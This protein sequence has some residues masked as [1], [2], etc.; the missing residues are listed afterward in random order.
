[1]G[2]FSMISRGKFGAWGIAFWGVM[3]TVV[4]GI[5][6]TAS[7]Q[8]E[9]GL[10]RSIDGLAQDGSLPGDAT[11]LDI[12]LTVSAIAGDPATEQLSAL[13]MDETLPPG[14]SFN[15]LVGGQQPVFG[16]APGAQGELPFGYIVVPALPFSFTYRVNVPAEPVL[17]ATFNGIIK[18]RTTGPEL[19]S[20]ES[21]TE[22]VGEINAVTSSRSLSGPG[23]IGEDFYIAGSEFTVTVT[24]EKTGSEAVQA[25][26]YRVTLSPGLSLVSVGGPDTPPIASSIGATGELEFGYIVVPAFPIQF[27]YTLAIAPSVSGP[28][29]LVGE[30]EYRFTEGSAVVSP[31]PIIELEA[32]PCVSFTRTGAVSYRAGD[33]VNFT[34]TLNADCPEAITALGVL[35]IVPDGWGFVSAGGPNTPDIANFFAA[36]NE[37]EFAFITAPAFPVVFTYTLS[38]PENEVRDPVPYCGEAI[39]RLGTNPEQRSR[40]VCTN[41]VPTVNAA[42]VITLT[43][44]AEITLECAT[45]YIEPGFS[46]FDEEDGDLTNDVI[47]SGTVDSNTPGDYVITYSVTDS[48]GATTEVFRT[49]TVEDTAAPV[50]TLQGGTVTVQCGGVLNDPGATASDICAGNISSA[51]VVSGEVDLGTPGS[52]TLTYNVSDPS[53]NAAA[54]VTRTV[55][56]VD[57]TPPVVTLLGPPAL[58]VECS[59]NFN[60]PGATATDACAGNV[61]PSIVVTGTVN[62]STPGTYTLTYRATDPSGNQSAP[63]T[64]TVTVVDTTLPTISFVQGNVQLSVECGQTYVDPGATATDTCAGALTVSIDTSAVDTSTA[65]TYV[66]S[67]SAV[68]PSGNERVRTREVQ[69]VDTTAPV[70]TLIGAN[71]LIVECGET[72]QDPGATAN[73]VCAG[74][75]DVSVDSSAV[76]MGTP[77]LYT[78]TYTAVDPSGNESQL[79]RSVEVRDTTAPV[80]TL[81]GEATVTLECADEYVD[82]GAT[83]VDSCAGDVSS[84]IVVEN[85]VDVTTPGA[86]TV[87]YSVADAFGNSSSEVRTVI[88]A[89]TSS[90]VISLVG[91][92]EVTVE[93]AEA[94]EELGATAIDV[95]DGD[96]S[97]AIEISGTVDTAVPGTYEITYTVSDPDG[98]EAEPV[99]RVVTVVDTTAPVITL[100]GPE[101]VSVTC[102]EPYVDAGATA[103]DSCDGI[104]AVT[105][106]S[107]AVDF[108]V[109]GEYTVLFE[110]VDTAG[111]VATATRTVFIQDNCFA[112]ICS[113]DNGNG[114]LDT[115]FLCL[116]AV[117]N[118]F[119]T[120]VES[121]NCQRVVEMITWF[122]GGNGNISATVQSP[123]DNGQ[124]VTVSVPR[125]AINRG[126]QGILVLSVSCDVP[127]LFSPEDSSF[128]EA[129]LPPDVSPTAPVFQAVLLVSKDNGASYSEVVSLSGSQEI[130]VTVTGL[131]IGKDNEPVLLQYPIEAFNFPGEGLAILPEQG[132]WEADGVNEAAFDGDTLVARLK[133]FSAFAVADRLDVPGELVAIPPVINF[134]PVRIGTAKEET[135]SIS[136]LGGKVI[137]GQARLVDDSRAFSLSGNSS[138][139]LAP[140]TLGVFTV[141]FQPSSRGLVVATV[142]LTGNDDGPTEVTIVGFGTLVDKGHLFLG[143]GPGGGSGAGL[144]DLLVVLL[145]AGGLTAWQLRRRYS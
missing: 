5:Q 48:E 62:T 101:F 134:G 136:N 20:E 49:V 4:A 39:F 76:N 59:V 142:E 114:L 23:I 86:Y 111:N 106:D 75:V 63:V 123:V 100:I 18:Y 27:S 40:E 7:G 132:M 80:I 104:V 89:N 12:T 138:Y 41:L 11:T 103:L 66:V 93:C 52:Y 15:S 83:A 72:Y 73:D 38:V 69:V 129:V 30:T 102:D 137:S 90:P 50:I 113:D 126:E 60:D 98:N 94:Y 121:D 139:E 145:L 108:E 91:E 37:L 68:D 116:N 16:P 79:T 118:T 17:P 65:G 34:I 92:A 42:P 124:V 122:D 67:Y 128:P 43:G 58:N 84:D 82:A 21:V 112:R 19:T 22:V 125:R 110:A 71:P 29:S 143:C 70:I 51:I 32:E 141:R 33:N 97:E 14:W 56:V 64:R 144:G 117:R 36:T 127:S 109:S 1:L 46:A 35:E 24:M 88:V 55:N 95:C 107:S 47:V 99:V 120:Q 44:N 13:G 61:T 81:N 140:G 31:S 53:G 8:L 28:L 57:S 87:T 3:L 78:V 2:R 115:P 135:L 119:V 25:L 6:A 9:L 45:S 77:G 105:V 96:L 133:S 74:S 130:E 85:N 10:E 26:G 131:I 54:P